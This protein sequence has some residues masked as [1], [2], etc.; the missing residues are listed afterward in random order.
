[1]KVVMIRQALVD[2]FEP[3]VSTLVLVLQACIRMLIWSEQMDFHTLLKFINEWSGH[4]DLDS[5][6]GMQRD[7]ANVQG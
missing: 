2:G 7:Y 6:L 5:I 3:N 1:M 4:I